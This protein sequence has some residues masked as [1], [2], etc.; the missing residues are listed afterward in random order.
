MVDAQCLKDGAQTMVDS[1]ALC[2]HTVRVHCYQCT[3]SVCRCRIVF[4][5]H[6]IIVI[7]GGC[8][9]IDDWKGRFIIRKDGSL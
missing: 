9:V 1:E 3:L 6:H 5:H 7:C 8:R 4:V 2:M